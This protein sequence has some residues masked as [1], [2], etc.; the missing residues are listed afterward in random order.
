MTEFPAPPETP[1]HA[2]KAPGASKA[3]RLVLALS[4]AANLAVVGFVAGHALV[5]RGH[6]GMS[7]DLAFGPFT[8]ALG[9][10]DRRALR[11]AL[12]A[13][14][15]D[16]RDAHMR[17]SQDLVGLVT[18]LRA[19]PFDPAALDAALA[20][21]SHRMTANLGMAHGVLRDFLIAMTPEARV[22]FAARLADRVTPQG[23]GSN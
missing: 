1:S 2:P 20:V 21:Q 10:H 11:D 9:Q 18:A 3:T 19:E 15:P 6:P 22:A 17:M 12:F 5:G 7:G 14:A 13:R 16:M 4:L 23:D 8:E